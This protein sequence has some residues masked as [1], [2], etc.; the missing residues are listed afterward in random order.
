[1]EGGH[2]GFTVW[3]EKQHNIGSLYGHFVLA[4]VHS[5]ESMKERERACTVKL[6]IYLYCGAAYIV[7]L[8][9]WLSTCIELSFGN[10]VPTLL[11]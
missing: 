3:S 9:S 7:L 4:M 11:G 5:T 10:R 6:S 2:V 1:M 8:V